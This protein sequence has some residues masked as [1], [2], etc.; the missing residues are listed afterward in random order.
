MLGLILGE[1]EGEIE[2][3][4]DVDGLIDSEILGEIL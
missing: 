2:L 1:M 3:L 4:G